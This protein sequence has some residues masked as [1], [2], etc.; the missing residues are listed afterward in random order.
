[1]VKIHQALVALNDPDVGCEFRHAKRTAV[2]QAGLETTPGVSA[3][4]AIGVEDT[5]HIQ[6]QY[7][8][9]FLIADLGREK[10][11]DVQ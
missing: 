7:H 8:A 4:L 1:V 2:E 11:P 5:L 6:S 3:R 10:R 9:F